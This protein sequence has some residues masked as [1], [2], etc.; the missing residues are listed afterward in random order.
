L[1]QVG[2]EII[3]LGRNT[4]IFPVEIPAGMTTLDVLIVPV[5]DN[6]YQA[7]KTVVVGLRPN[8][9]YESSFGFLT[10]TTVRI[11]EDDSVPD[12][13]IPTVRIEHPSRAR[14]S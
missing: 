14:R 1:V 4:Q 5:D 12:T 6:A 10:N 8:P 11:I 13:I 3:E 2:G 7:T 9:N